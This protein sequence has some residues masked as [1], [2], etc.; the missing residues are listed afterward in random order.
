MTGTMEIDGVKSKF[1]SFMFA[2]IEEATG[3]MI[4]CP[5][6]PCGD[7]RWAIRARCALIALSHPGTPGQEFGSRR[8]ATMAKIIGLH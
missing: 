4:L 6:G 7:R 1:E 3:R 8:N 2:Q 5:R